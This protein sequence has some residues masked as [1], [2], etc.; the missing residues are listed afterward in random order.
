MPIPPVLAIET[1]IFDSVTVSIA[2]EKKGTL[3]FIDLVN[4]VFKIVSEGSTDEYF[5]S[6]KTSSKVRTDQIREK[7]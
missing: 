2:A 6:S 1:A 5:G 7:L 3:S 4:S